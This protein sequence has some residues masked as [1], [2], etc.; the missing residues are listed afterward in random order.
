MSTP[1]DKIAADLR[2]E[3]EARLASWK[4]ERGQLQ[5]AA[6]RM[7]ELDALIAF[8][9]DDTKT[10]FRVAPR[11]AQPTGTETRGDVP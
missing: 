7:A 9:D 1:E 5:K 8:A 4:A 10:Q 6:E 2:S 11:E 3:I